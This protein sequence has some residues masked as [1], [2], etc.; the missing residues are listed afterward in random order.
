MFK[1][2]LLIFANQLPYRC[3]LCHRSLPRLDQTPADVAAARV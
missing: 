2:L 3:C 1:K